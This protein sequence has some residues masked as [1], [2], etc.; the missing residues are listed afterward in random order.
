[1]TQ[2]EYPIGAS[3]IHDRLDKIH[4]DAFRLAWKAL[5]IENSNY[6]NLGVLEKYKK[7]QLQRG[8]TQGA[9]KTQGQLDQLLKLN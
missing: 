7:Q 5:Q 4:N 9:T 3:Y 6:Q 2:K 1:M 8:D